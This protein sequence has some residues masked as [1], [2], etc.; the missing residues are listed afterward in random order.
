MGR[1]IDMLIIAGCNI[2]KRVI[3]REVLWDSE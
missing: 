3:M 2:G 1:Q